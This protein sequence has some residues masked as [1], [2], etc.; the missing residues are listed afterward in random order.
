[1]F[2]I[3]LYNKLGEFSKYFVSS[4]LLQQKLENFSNKANLGRLIEV[5]ICC[6]LF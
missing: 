1:M 5:N 3:I 6:E 4:L 2:G